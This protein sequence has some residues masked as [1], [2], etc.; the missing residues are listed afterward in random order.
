MERDFRK[1]ECGRVASSQRKDHSTASNVNR[2]YGP[3]LED[4][5]VHP[6][7]TYALVSAIKYEL[8]RT[9]FDN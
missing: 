3:L 4:H 7:K 1:F 6:G 9:F 5:P 2:A 8:G